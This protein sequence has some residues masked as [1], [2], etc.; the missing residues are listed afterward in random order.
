MA[1]FHVFQIV[2]IVPNRA[3][4]HIYRCGLLV[5]GNISRG[6]S[7]DRPCETGAMTEGN[8]SR[9]RAKKTVIIVFIA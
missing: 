3:T 2:Q 4:H 9:H 7:T 1:V 8:I 5:L 6:L